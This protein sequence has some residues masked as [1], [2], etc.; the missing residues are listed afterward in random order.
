LPTLK[1]EPNRII[2]GALVKY[3]DNRGGWQRHDGVPLR[4]G[5]QYLGLGTRRALQ[6]FIDRFPEVITAETNDALPDAD[7][8]NAQIPKTEWPIGLAGQPEGPWKREF[9]VYMIDIFDL[10]ILTSSNHTIGMTRAVTDLEERWDWARALYGADVMPLLALK[11]APFPT[12][13][14]ERKRPLFEITG[15]RCFRDGALRIVDQN[16]VALGTVKP[17][18][19]SETLNDSIPH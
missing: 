13:Y 18:S 6:R 9:I 16:A 12:D 2:V 1:L 4:S 11:E 7:E 15:W 5:A 3:I 14:G 10:T 8:L 17:K 19:L